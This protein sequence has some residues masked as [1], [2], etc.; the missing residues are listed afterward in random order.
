MERENKEQ[1]QVSELCYFPKRFPN[2][3][4]SVT[5]NVFKNCS[6]DPTIVRV[7]ACVTVS[8]CTFIVGKQQRENV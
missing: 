2:H 6:E 8:L 1:S 4:Y 5:G 7:R 3:T